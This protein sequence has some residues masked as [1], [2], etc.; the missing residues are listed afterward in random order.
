MSWPGRFDKLF[1][2]V[3]YR[4]FRISGRNFEKNGSSPNSREKPRKV[5]FSAVFAILNIRKRIRWILF[6]LMERTLYYDC[7][8]KEKMKKSW[9]LEFWRIFKV[10]NLE[11]LVNFSIFF[12]TNFN[13]F[14]KILKFCYPRS[15]MI[16]S[17]IIFGNFAEKNFDLPLKLK[18]L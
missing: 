1:W 13:F 14:R 16:F 5:H 12:C 6:F 15:F 11:F 17:S 7:F 8:A 18:I 10:W 4:W 2:S 9:K 3:L